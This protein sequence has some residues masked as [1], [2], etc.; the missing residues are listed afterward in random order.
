MKDVLVINVLPKPMYEDCRI[1]GSLSMPL[2]ALTQFSTQIPK[3]QLIVLYCAHYT[4]DA[5]R[6]AWKVLHDLGFTNVK[7]YEGGMA[8]WNQKGYPVEGACKESYLKKEAPKPLH[9]EVDQIS[10]EQ[11]NKLLNK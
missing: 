5:S 3:D 8:E 1:K 10:I 6:R 9:S 11:L 2:A 4:C 7:A